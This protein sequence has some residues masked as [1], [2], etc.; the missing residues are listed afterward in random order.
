M[1]SKTSFAALSEQD[2]QISEDYQRIAQAI[3]FIEANVHHQPSLEEIAASVHL[4]EYHFQRLFTRWA[5]ISPKRFMKFLTKES[6]KELLDASASVLEATYQVGLS[7]PG[8]LHDL[9]VT[10]EAVTPGEYKQRGSGLTIRY[11]FHPSPFGECLLAVTE[12]GI[13]GLMFVDPGVHRVMLADLEHRWPRA[14]LI[15]DQVSTWPY[16][17]RIFSAPEP[18]TTPL[19]LFLSG[20]NFQLQVWQALLQI[21]AGQAISYESVAEAVGHPGAARAAGSAIGDNPIAVLIPCHR[22]LRKTGELGGYRYGL[23]RKKA[24][25]GWE[26]ALN[27]PSTAI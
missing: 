1:D 16:I 22:V 7:S 15:Q 13:C 10:T 4:S 12:R 5:G 11:G 24:L 19:P 26:T 17:H 25:L 9:F 6:A 18:A 23:A 2:Q 21:P 20:T 8:R 14:R 3:Q 27:L